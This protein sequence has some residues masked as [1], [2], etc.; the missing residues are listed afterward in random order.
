MVDLPAPVWPTSATV[1]RGR[2]TRFTPVSASSGWPEYRNCTSRNSICPCGCPAGRPAQHFLDPPQADSCLLVAVEDLGE[3]LYRGEEQ[4]DVQQVGDEAAGG[5]RLVLHLSRGHEQDQRAGHGG[6]QLHE[7]EVQ[8]NVALRAQARVA[9]A[10]AE[11]AKVL[12]IPLLA[13]VGL[14]GP[15]PGHVLLQVGV[16]GADLLPGLAVCLR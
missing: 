13:P 9:V 11:G 2:T 12:V 10:V 5:Q 15:Q 16:D 6:Q 3:L 14:R 8:R 7:R 4:V 1:S